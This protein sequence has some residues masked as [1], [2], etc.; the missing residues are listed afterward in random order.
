MHPAVSAFSNSAAGTGPAM[1]LASNTQVSDV[2]VSVSTDSMLNDTWAALRRIRS[3]TTR[4]IAA[5]VK[6]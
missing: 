1:P 6:M 4:S 3:S 2:L 5:S